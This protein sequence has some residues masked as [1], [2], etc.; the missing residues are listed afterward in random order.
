MQPTFIP[1]VGYFKMI[2]SCD[3]FIFLDDVQF[4]KR[5]FQSRNKI[6]INNEEKIISVPTHV[7]NKFKQTINEVEINYNEKWVEK[8][9]KS[10]ELNYKKH[11]F[12]MENF[13]F[14]SKIL[15]RR[16]KKLVNLNLKLIIEICK[17]LNIKTKFQLAS[18][19]DVNKK[20]GLRIFELLKKTK[21]TKYLSPIRSKEY[22][23]ENTEIFRNNNLKIEYLEYKC[24]NYSQKNS[25]NFISHL[26]IIDLLFNEGKNSKN[27]V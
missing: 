25:D 27:F 15:N 9:L 3:L 11:E 7:K 19:Y 17:Y 18:S 26:S 14:I 16:E 4:E 2:M 21:A 8:H 12:F 22:L 23:D 1:W 10:I 13:E 24:Q 6:L 5:S 20:K